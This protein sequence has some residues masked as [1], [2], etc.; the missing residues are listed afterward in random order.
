M[1][2]IHE[3]RIVDL[4]SPRPLTW[5][6]PFDGR[7]TATEAGVTESGIRA[8]F[9]HEVSQKRQLMPELRKRVEPF[10]KLHDDVQNDPTLADMERWSDKQV[11][12]LMHRLAE[13]AET[14]LDHQESI[15]PYCTR[16]AAFQAEHRV[17][18]EDCEDLLAELRSIEAM[19]AW[20]ERTLRSWSIDFCNEYERRHPDLPKP[21][22]T[23]VDLGYTNSSRLPEVF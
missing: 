1:V 14:A 23:P 20:S 2:S 19:L 22:N 6:R 9:D 5:L 4:A 12:S 13:A 10:Q 17:D 11:L 16:L 7:E 8:L 3:S 15:G 21:P 18:S